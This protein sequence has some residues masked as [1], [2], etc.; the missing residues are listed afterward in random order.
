LFCLLKEVAGSG[1]D[2]KQLALVRHKEDLKLD[3]EDKT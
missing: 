3:G 1:R 2:E